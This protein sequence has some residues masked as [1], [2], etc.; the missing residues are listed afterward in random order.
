MTAKEIAST[1]ASQWQDVHAALTRIAKSKSATD[2]EEAAWLLRGLRERVYVHLGYGSYLE[3]LERI[4]GYTPRVGMERLRVAHALEELPLLGA[5]LRD[6]TFTWSAVREITRVA[7]AETEVDWIAYSKGKS[8]RQIEELVS[9]LAKGARP[10]DPARDEL[11]R[12][13][14]RFEVQGETLAT[15]RDAR[16]FLE[17]EAGHSLSEDEVLLLLARRALGGPSDEG[18]SSYQIAVSVC[19]SCTRGWQQAAGENVR[20]GAA[21]V[22]M[23]E[24]DAQRIS[25]RKAER[26]SQTIPPSVRRLVMRRD[27]GRCIVP[28]C[29][30]T[31]FLDCHHL[32]PRHEGGDHDPD[33][34]VMLCSAHHR[35]LHDGLLFIE[36]KVSTGL[37]FLHADGSGY[38]G[39]VSPKTAEVSAL[40]FQA[41]KKMGY[42]DSEARR[43]VQAAITHVGNGLEGVIRRALG[44]LCVKEEEAPYGSH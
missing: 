40:A 39:E 24:C 43:G 23:A 36:G 27:R 44:E 1:E 9:G 13:V 12:H 38:G 32:D 11:R 14:L 15:F 29:R 31:K 41:L 3:Y 34:L 28:G 42:A 21:I 6:G 35:A 26:A 5:A 17:Q 22:E 19:E 10:T 4:F 8:V 25:V 30:A 7:V 2:F 18:K 16:L 20:V 37:R 33:N